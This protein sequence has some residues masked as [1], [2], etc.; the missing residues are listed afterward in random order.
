MKKEEIKPLLI[1]VDEIEYRTDLHKLEELIK[2][3]GKKIEIAFE[4]T[5]LGK[6]TNDYLQRILKKDLSGIRNAITDV[7]SKV[8]DPKYLKSEI[9]NNVDSKMKSLKH[10]TMDLHAAID[11][12][13]LYGLKEYISATSAGKITVS[14]NDKKRLK[15]SHSTYLTT[16]EGITRYN[17]HKEA[18]K[19]INDFV[20]AMGDLLGY[21]DALQAFGLDDN[22]RV[23]PVIFDYE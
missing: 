3:H 23:I 12:R 4:A 15:D 14:N 19:A 6:L 21:S 18:C 5:G 2:A 7:I 1:E 13:G 16:E 11:L 10:E 8:L 22:E 17:L 9:E 20:D